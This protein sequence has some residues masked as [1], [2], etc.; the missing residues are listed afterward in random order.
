VELPAIVRKVNDEILAEFSA[1][2]R[3]SIAGLP[4]KAA[5]FD[6]PRKK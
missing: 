6:E 3:A 5:G 1:T 4:Q 2:E